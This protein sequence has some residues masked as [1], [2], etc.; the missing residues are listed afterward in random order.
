MMKIAVT[1]A[2]GFVGKRFVSYNKDRFS[3]HP[4]HLKDVKIDNLD[5][6]GMDAIVHLAGKAHQMIPIDDNIYFEVNYELTKSLAELAKKQ[7]VKQFIYISSTKVYGDDVAE[8]VNEQSACKP[9]DAYG[10]SKLKAEQYLI[11][12]ESSDFKIAIVRPPLVYGP[13]VKGNMIKLLALAAKKYTLP[14][15]DTHNARSMVFVD[16]LIALINVI[17]EKKATGVFVAGDAH[18]VSTSYLIKSMRDSLGNRSKLMAVPGFLR[19]IIRLVKPGLYKRL[20]GSFVVD[21]TA[22]NKQ[23]NFMP[24]YST[25]EGVKQMVSWFSQNNNSN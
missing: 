14:F 7:G 19:S 5:I 23:L 21:N 9:T 24:P 13:G 1:G 18:P 4:L 20:F 11:K 16:N 12:L 10:A 15:G 17:L 6:T 8:A 2:T 22:T 3:L 25:A